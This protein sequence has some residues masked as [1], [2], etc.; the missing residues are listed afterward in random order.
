MTWVVVDHT[1][2]PGSQGL[3][4]TKGQQVEVVECT[5]DLC[6][7]RLVDSSRD[8]PLEGLVPV[9]VLKPPPHPKPPSSPSSRHPPTPTD[10]NQG[11]SL[12]FIHSFS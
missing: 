2:T 4:V 7:V 10:S 11:K 12:L 8:L 9:S 6:L 1:A 5:G 3:T